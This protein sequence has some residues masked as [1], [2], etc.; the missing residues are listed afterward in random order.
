MGLKNDF[1]ASEYDA[2]LNQIVDYVYD[3]KPTNPVA[4]TR[5]KACLIDSLGVVL[6]TLQTSHE[7]TKLLGPP[8]P[9]TS[10]TPNGVKVPGTLYQL[11]VMK[12]AFDIGALIR[13]LDH[14]D[15]FPGAEWGHPSDNLGAILATTDILARTERAR[16]NNTCIPTVGTICEALIKAYEIQGVFQIK[17][18][19]NQ[20]GLDHTI[21]VKIASTAVASWL[22]RLSREQAVIA[23]SH[24]WCD[25]HP[26]RAYRQY[27][28]AGPRK[29]WAAGEACKQA[30][31]L[32]FLAK[33]GQPGMKTIL[34]CPKWG[35]YDVLFKGKEFDLPQPFGSWVVENVLYK[36]NT[37]EG[38]GM[39]GVE[40]ALTIANEL[41]TQG[42]DPSKDIQS[43]SIRTQKPAMII[44]DKLRPLTNPADRDHCLRYMCAVVLL[45]GSMVETADYQNDS[46]W[47]KDPR[48]EDLRQRMT[49][50][51]DPQL[52][53]DYHNL[54]KRSVP[55]ALTVT[56]KDGTV[57]P[58]V[59]VEYPQGHVARADTLELVEKKAAHNLRMV[60]P[61]AKVEEI[62]RM[63]KSDEFE[64]MPVDTFMDLFTPAH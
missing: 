4:W 33:A 3:Y 37:A 19:F 2:V 34:T 48:I 49:M 18:A 44:I 57:M 8:F 59:L 1:E 60:L 53:A 40:A 15:A 23:V 54:K 25:G 20:V 5:A 38:H 61:A 36:V 6:E 29:G 12:G 42:L 30:V 62:I 31:H 52:T 9:G 63:Y 11:D 26:L 43:I 21:L 55:N 47:A 39:T 50:Y 22:L 27:P 10:V 13:Y 51:E 24:A 7:I 64:Q 17:N 14:S 28:N 41:K 16:G 56:L 35:F 45:K 46:P 58:E 32:A